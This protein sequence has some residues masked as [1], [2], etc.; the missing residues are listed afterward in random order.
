[1]ADDEVDVLG[2]AEVGQSVPAEDALDA[3]DQVVA[4]GRDELEERGG[5]GRD[6]LASSVP[7]WSTTQ[8]CIVRAWRSMPQ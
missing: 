8:T 7:S 6:V 2:G 3:D 5:V 1:M 4:V